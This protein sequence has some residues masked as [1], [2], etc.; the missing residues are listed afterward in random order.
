MGKVHFIMYHRL[1]VNDHQN[2]PHMR[3]RGYIATT[4]NVKKN[5]LFHK[6]KYLDLLYCEYIFKKF[7]Q[8]AF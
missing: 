6:I 7:L 5:I 3:E 2:E 1:S 4:L 8:P